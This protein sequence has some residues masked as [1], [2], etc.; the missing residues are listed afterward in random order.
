MERREGRK[1]LN[2]RYWTCR[3]LFQFAVIGCMCAI[4]VKA[5]TLQVIQHSLWVHKSDACLD[6]KFRVPAY[7]GTIYDRKGR[8]LAYSVP[9]CSLYTF[10]FQVKDPSKTAALL[11]PILDEP[12]RSI[13]K[14]LTSTSHF[15][16][17]K[18]DLTD[19]Q[20]NSIRELKAPCLHLT[21]E[22]K[23]FYPYRQLAGQ[24]IGLV[25]IDGVGITGIEKSF[26]KVLRRRTEPVCALR[27]GARRILW[28]SDAAPP[29]PAESCGIKLS[30]DAFIEYV[31]ESALAKAAAKFHAKQAEAIVMDPRTREVLAMANWPFFDPNIR[32]EKQEHGED[33]TRNHCIADAFEPGSTFKIVLMSAALNQGIFHEFSRLYC[34]NGRWLL[35]GHI[36]KDVHP[37]GWLTL[38]QVLKFSSNIGAAKTALTLGGP[39]FDRYIK[40]F[41]F[42][43][44]TGIALPGEAGGLLRP[45]KYWK[46]LDLAVTG[47]GQS[48]G[49]TAIQ[50]ENAVAVV[51][52][53]GVRGSPIIVDSI[54]G[55]HGRTIRKLRSLDALRVIRKTTANVVRD[56]MVTVTQPGGTG[57]EAVPVGYTVAGKTGTAQVM[58]ANTKRYSTTDYTAVFTGFAPADNPRL[59]ITVVVHDP[60]GSIYGGVVAAPVFRK[61]AATVL[62][63]LGAMPSSPGFEPAP[64]V[65]MAKTSS[66]RAKRGL[67]GK[68]AAIK[69]PAAH[70]KIWAES[71]LEK[72]PGAVRPPAGKVRP[73]GNGASWNGRYSLKLAKPEAALY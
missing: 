26:D 41:G 39:T 53:G 2:S 20:T 70:R 58:N 38:Q 37:N 21:T 29:E 51:A 33:I 69:R 31:T 43:S 4:I 44:P 27:D 15:V 30:L 60:Q 3:A 36:I 23:R 8:V 54:L 64:T 32:P 18:R 50:L 24:V 71:D 62:P 63:Y 52:S 25:N 57:V 61:I 65:R 49:V 1:S 35:A 59:V 66:G 10:G 7:R 11:S 13:E 5:F 40:A 68:I 55:P 9:Q 12:A 17:I 46:Q 28:L 19:Q 22:Y 48:I 16:W 56:M 14:Q 34:E 47:F 67:F 42:G 45:L 73:T 6:T 72:N